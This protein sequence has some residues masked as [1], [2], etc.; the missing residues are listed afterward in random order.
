MKTEEILT[1]Q[2]RQLIDVANTATQ[3]INQL[4]ATIARRKDYDYNNVEACKTLDVNMNTH[5]SKMAS[6]L[7][8]FASCFKEIAS[9][10]IKKMG[11]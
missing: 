7:K 6:N 2:A 4:H 3:D 10:L 11:K 5:F 9:S 8:T 1:K